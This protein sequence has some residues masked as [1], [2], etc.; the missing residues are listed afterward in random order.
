MFNG[1]TIPPPVRII[2]ASLTLAS[3]HIQDTIRNLEKLP[4]KS[5]NAKLVTMYEETIKIVSTLKYVILDRES[6]DEDRII[7]LLTEVGLRLFLKTNDNAKAVN[8]GGKSR[9]LLMG[10]GCKF[11]NACIGLLKGEY[12]MESVRLR[13]I[14]FYLISH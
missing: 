9:F 14:I 13:V 2:H 5:N 10:L 6:E 11:L 12:L 3:I 7:R 8:V 1:T 4:V